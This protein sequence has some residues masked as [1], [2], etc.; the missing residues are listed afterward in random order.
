PMGE[1]PNEKGLSRKH[2]MEECHASLRRL[3]TD[4]IDLYQC[5]RFDPNVPVEE[6]VRAMDDLIH[7]GKV[8]YWGVSTWSAPQTRQCLKICGERYCK[9]EGWEPSYE[10][11][12][13]G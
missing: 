2:I 9:P 1:G 12:G 8:I 10:M 13:R 6:V 7:Q 3:R 4:H 5:H 11:M